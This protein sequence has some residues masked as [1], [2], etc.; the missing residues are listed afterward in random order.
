MPVLLVLEACRFIY[1]NHEKVEGG[2][3]V[4][5]QDLWYFGNRSRVNVVA[6]K[7][8][9]AREWEESLPWGSELEVTG[10]TASLQ[11]LETKVERRNQALLFLLHI[12]EYGSKK[13]Q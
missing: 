9:D 10:H 2:H 12:T 11:C 5:I 4:T 13:P 6:G 1:R 7:G 3:A 8:P